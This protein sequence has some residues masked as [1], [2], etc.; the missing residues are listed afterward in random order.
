MSERSTAALDP[1]TTNFVVP[2]LA[3]GRPTTLACGAAMVR[4]Q[5]MSVPGTPHSAE[6]TNGRFAG[7]RRCNRQPVRGHVRERVAAALNAN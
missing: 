6:L 3:A 2:A 1:A 7:D 5:T 4:N